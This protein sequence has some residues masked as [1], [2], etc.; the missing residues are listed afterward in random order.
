MGEET[1]QVLRMGVEQGHG[2]AEFGPFGITNA[3]GKQAAGDIDAVDYIADVVQDFGGQL[4]L[5]GLTGGFQ[6]LLVG[7]FQGLLGRVRRSISSFSAR[8]ANRTSRC[9][10]RPAAPVAHGPGGAPPELVCA[11]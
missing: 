6:Q 1:G 5:A 2:L 10:P 11:R 4:R 9:A 3:F 8:L 7:G